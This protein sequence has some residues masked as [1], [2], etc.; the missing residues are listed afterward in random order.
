MW[1]WRPDDEA[2][3]ER[4]EDEEALERLFRHHTGS[5]SGGQRP[6]PRAAGLV[7]EVRRL[8]GGEAAVRAA[9]TGD[10]AKLA[11]IVDFSEPARR[12]PELLHHTAVY[13]AKVASALEV[14][15]P[16]HAANAWMRSLA[17]WLALGEERTYLARLEEAVLGKSD[18]GGVGGAGGVRAKGGS[19][20]A[21]ASAVIPPERVPLELLAELGKR[22][23]ATSRDLSAPGR[24]ALLA[25]SWVPEAAR[26]AGVSD[27]TASR[28]RAAAERRRNAA[29]DAALTV[30][31]EALDEANVRGEL[32]R[33][34]RTIL[35]RAIDVWKWS[36]GDEIVEQFAADKLA[37]VGWELYRARD[38]DGLRLTF[39]PF[40]P[41]I[42]SFAQRLEKDRTKIA[43]AAPC[44]QLFVFLTDIEPVLARKTELAERAVRLCPSHRNG[45][46]N[47][48]SLL[49]E[50]A[51]AT[52][53]TMVLFARKDDLDRVEQ[54]IE[55]A[56]KLYPQST[57]LPEA[58]AMLERVR[59]GRLAL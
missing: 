29:L 4:L 40:R 52:M 8:P 53:R 33:A 24:A 34:G 30:L 23:E 11:R 59:R 47:L 45:R 6:H 31:G 7:A 16:E 41:M 50:Q 49:C 19:A 36:G 26:M 35:V 22:A 5:V 54:Q 48:A 3:L 58:K 14:A 56:E 39:E 57:E 1:T 55:R 37:A 28:A 9:L 12:S 38:W 27:D 21:N 18:G 25:L 10:V 17:A 51:I 20:S 13:F 42:E 32:G 46:L 44:A 15:A 2:L 43:Y